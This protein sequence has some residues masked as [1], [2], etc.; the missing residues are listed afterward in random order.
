MRAAPKWIALPLSCLALAAVFA[1][2]APPSSDPSD[3]EEI[4]AEESH[5]SVAPGD[6]VDIGGVQVVAPMAGNGV[7]AEVIDESG[8]THTLNLRT[9]DA[10]EVFIVHDKPE[11]DDG[12]DPDATDAPAQAAGEAT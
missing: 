5:L 3:D 11:I 2:C 7:F 4:A 12:P 8:V 9:D 6:A 1:G 10:S